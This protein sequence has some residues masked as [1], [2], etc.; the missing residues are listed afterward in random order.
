MKEP[1]RVS[2]PESP[3]R[4]GGGGRDPKNMQGNA[5]TPQSGAG[6]DPSRTRLVRGA[7]QTPTV[8]GPGVTG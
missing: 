3:A 6:P 2:H 4:G 7:T 8:A 5:V 1:F